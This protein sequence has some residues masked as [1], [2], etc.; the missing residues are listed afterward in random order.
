MS[1]LRGLLDTARSALL[2]HQMALNV[3]GHNVA[4][5]STEGYT[6]QRLDLRARAG[7]D[8]RPAGIGAGVEALG[9]ERL[10]VESFERSF[11]AENSGLG[12]SEQKSRLLAGVEAVLGEP[13]DAGV[14][15]A[16]D[17]FWSAWADLGNEPAEES[18]RRAVVEA[19]ARL[20]GRLNQLDGQLQAQRLDI[21]LEVERIAAQ[22]GDKAAQVAELS[23]RI[24]AAELD[25]GTASDLRDLR[26]LLVDEL[27]RLVDLSAGEDAQGVFRVWVGNRALVDGGRA[28]G[29]VLT[30]ED[31][32]SGT[33]LAR[34]SWS[35]TGR[36]LAVSAGELAGALETRDR[37]LPARMAE[38]DALA[39]ALVERVNGLHRA[40]VDLAGR[41]GHDFFDGAG[42]GARGIALSRW[43]LEDPARVAASADGGVGN[44]EQA[45][46]IAQLAAQGLAEL[47]GLSLG[48]AWGSL[49]SQC[50]AETARADAELA[51]QQS[52]VAELDT[53]RQAVAGVN[54]DEELTLMMEQEQAY[55]AAARVVTTANALLQ[56]VLDLVS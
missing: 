2:A 6:R 13:G 33:P 45:T 10:R 5:V 1:T 9:V 20:A 47:S 44:G 25:G 35:D 41:P 17:R 16:L 51:A 31:D 37:L 54:L 4:N 23:R 30:R 15:Q 24:Q 18:Y 46:A 36:E 32:G 19:G 56:E 49:V 50:G 29:L 39:E 14:G 3:T 28:A 48:E 43:V 21:N 12:A 22:V 52:F 11:H 42:G 40:G 53:R 38:L 34:L 8:Q 26:G 27:S 55:Q 7:S